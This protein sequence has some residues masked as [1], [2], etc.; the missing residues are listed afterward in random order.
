MRPDCP[1]RLFVRIDFAGVLGTG[2]VAPN[3]D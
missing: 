1:S 3:D 2:G